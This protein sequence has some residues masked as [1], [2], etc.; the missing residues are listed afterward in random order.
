MS[1]TYLVPSLDYLVPK[2]KFTL[3]TNYLFC[4]LPNNSQPI[5][6]HVCFNTEKVM[7]RPKIIV[8][9][10]DISDA[11]GMKE[12]RFQIEWGNLRFSNIRELLLS[13]A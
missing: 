11:G 7:L 3:E 9:S 8:F 4:R 6:A 5:L 12:L 10:I 13:W 1:H 2:G